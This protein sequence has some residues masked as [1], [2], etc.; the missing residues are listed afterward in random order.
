[1]N[2]G[3]CVYNIGMLA[4]PEGKGARRGAAQGEIRIR[5][6]AWVAADA[7]G[8]IRAVGIGEISEEYSA[9]EFSRIDAGG[10][11]VTPGLIDAHTHL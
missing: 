6:D 10:R 4:T 1:M 8:V 5:R 7:D 9:E 2:R 11:L 3:I